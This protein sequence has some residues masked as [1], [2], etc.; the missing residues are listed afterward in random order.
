MAYLCKR[1]NHPFS[2]LI[3]APVKEYLYPEW[4]AQ[5]N[6]TSAYALI[7][8]DKLLGRNAW[9]VNLKYKTG[10]ATA[11]IDQSTGIILKYSQ[12]EN[13]RK[14]VDASFTSLELDMSIDAS[15]FRI[16][17]GYSSSGQP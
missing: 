15:V 9:I 7:G 1:S 8:E 14:F 12:E 3:P 13:G 10:Q 11:W 16:P 5:G 6:P 17:V 4:F 2:L